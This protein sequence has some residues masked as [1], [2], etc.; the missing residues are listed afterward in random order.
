MASQAKLDIAYMKM[1]YNAAELS[2]AVRRKVGAILVVPN[3]GRFEGT[4]G[5]PSGFDNCCEDEVDDTVLDVQKHS[6]VSLSIKNIPIKCLVTKPEVLHAESNAI[7]KVARSHA[8]SVGG[9]L[10]CT[11]APCLECAKLII[12]A[13]IVRVV[14]G[15]Q[16]PYPGHAGVQRAVG[17]E[18]L[19]R[20]GIIVDLL[21]IKNE[22][23][24]K[25]LLQRDDGH[26]DPSAGSRWI[27]YRP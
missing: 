15:E 16:Y 3:E 4:N 24:E 19:T 5:M 11:L 22:H 7:M 13:G 26:N 27:N 8:S 17:L 25:E 18:L 23:D 6:E 12:Q 9:T 2:H 10:Y 20:A 1:A 14:Y 21:C